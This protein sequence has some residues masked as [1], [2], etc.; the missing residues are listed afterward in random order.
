MML[1]LEPNL[2]ACAFNG[3]LK[4]LTLTLTRLAYLYVLLQSSDTVSK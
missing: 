2:A 1:E 4:N 3:E